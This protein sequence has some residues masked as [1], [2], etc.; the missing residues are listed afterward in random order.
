MNKKENLEHNKKRVS[1]FLTIVILFGIAGGVISEILGMVMEGGK[2][3]S[4]LTHGIELSIKPFEVNLAVLNFTFGIGIKFTL[5]TLI[6][7]FL[8]GFLYLKAR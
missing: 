8:G 4:I 1:F 2:L 3:K 6:F 5:I 7:M